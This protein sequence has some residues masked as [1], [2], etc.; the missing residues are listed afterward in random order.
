MGKAG[1]GGQQRP[2]RLLE[3]TSKSASYPATEA[4]T[5]AQSAGGLLQRFTV[6]GCEIVRAEASPLLE[7]VVQGKH[8]RP[9][10]PVLRED[11]QHQLHEVLGPEPVDDAAL[12]LGEGAAQ[13]L[14]QP[15]AVTLE[16]GPGTPGLG[17]QFLILDRAPTTTAVPWRVSRR[18][19]SLWDSALL[20]VIL[21]PL[22]EQACSVLVVPQTPLGP[23]LVVEIP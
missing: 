16:E 20:P 2:T 1:L 4:A 18:R 13:D 5:D 23:Q 17:G 9:G 10:V 15:A 11:L 14:L 19:R 6:V 12:K 22:P 3:A 8:H 21:S 7:V